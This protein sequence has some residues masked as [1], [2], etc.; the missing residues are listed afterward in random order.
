MN[1]TPDSVLATYEASLNQAGYVI[2]KYDGKWYYNEI[3]ATDDLCDGPYNSRAEVLLSACRSL[4]L[5][6]RAA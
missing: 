3:E 5:L 4:H 1:E 6:D 2:F